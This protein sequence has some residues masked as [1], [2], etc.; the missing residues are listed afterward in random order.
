MN[1]R[2]RVVLQQILVD[3]DDRIDYFPYIFAY[4][5][6]LNIGRDV[7]LPEAAA[8]SSE[9]INEPILPVQQTVR[10]RHEVQGL[11]RSASSGSDIELQTSFGDNV[12]VA[13]APHD[14]YLIS[15]F[16]RTMRGNAV[17][18]FSYFEELVGL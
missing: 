2:V 4:I 6:S 14:V 11:N 17:G 15:Y 8:H 12:R 18:Q 3:L 9:F 5:I 10:G 16:D 1:N 13:I 7:P